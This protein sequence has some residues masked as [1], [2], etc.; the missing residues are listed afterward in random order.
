MHLITAWCSCQIE[1]LGMLYIGFLLEMIMKR[2]G[3][4]RAHASSF[5]GGM[6][7]FTAGLALSCGIRLRKATEMHGLDQESLAYTKTKG[8]LAERR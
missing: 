1:W 2:V 5:F 8:G 6:V 3:R 4:H 7:R